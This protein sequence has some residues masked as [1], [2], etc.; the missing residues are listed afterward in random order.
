M[1]SLS[2]RLRGLT[3][4]GGTSP[5]FDVE[6]AP[7]DPFDLFVDWFDSAVAAGQL[8]PHALTLST[9]D[10]AG[11]PDARVV[12][13]K[14]LTEDGWWFASGSSSAKGR[15]LAAT[16][17]AAITF[18]WPTVARS[19]R[20]RGRVTEATAEQNAADFLRRGSGAR[21][22]AL[23][24]QQS[25][26]VRDPGDV[27][28][29]VAS[30]SDALSANPGLVSDTWTLWCVEPE[31]VEFWQA[32]RERRHVRVRYQRSAVSADRGDDRGTAWERVLLWP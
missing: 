9:I 19:V 32:D 14:D 21:A 5:A 7:A 18:Y 29:A 16:P 31:S 26:I 23:S 8:E 30:A 13:L 27:D 28:K 11:F 25:S 2:D 20:I 15:Q 4:L 17:R 24:G 12:I 1:D 6:K 22:V 10:S 3:A